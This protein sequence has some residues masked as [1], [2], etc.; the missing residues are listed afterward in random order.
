MSVERLLGRRTRHG[1]RCSK[2]LS[3]NINLPGVGVPGERARQRI[4]GTHR[5]AEYCPGGTGMAI[6]G[7]YGIY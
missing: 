5:S 6:H 3:A 1:K 4:V 2:G 7:T